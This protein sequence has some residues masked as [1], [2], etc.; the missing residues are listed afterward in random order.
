ML[1]HALAFKGMYALCTINK[2]TQKL[3]AIYYCQ[4]TIMGPAPIW[5]VWSA[6]TEKVV[7]LMGS[8]TQIEKAY[9]YL[10]WRRRMVTFQMIDMK[11]KSLEARRAELEHTYHK[12]LPKP[13]P[14]EVIPT[15]RLLEYHPQIESHRVVH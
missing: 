10:V 13:E 9:S 4:C 3:T 15:P 7:R 8:K 12:R 11:N 5:T 2:Q 14:K 1:E 6:K